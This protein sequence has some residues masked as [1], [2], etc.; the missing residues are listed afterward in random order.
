[1]LGGWEV[2]GWAL[3][4]V[5]ST[6]SHW[7]AWTTRAC[8]GGWEVAELYAQAKEEM[9]FVSTSPPNKTESVLQIPKETARQE[10]ILGN[11]I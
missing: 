4:G 6:I 7:L 11:S 9:A 10:Q 3:L 8:K 5:T 2:F 1:M